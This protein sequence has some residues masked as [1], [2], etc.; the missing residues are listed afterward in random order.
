MSV[1]LCGGQ[2]TL[3]SRPHIKLISGL[4]LLVPGS[5]DRFSSLSFLV[6]LLMFKSV[7]CPLPEVP[8]PV[9][10]PDPEVLC[11]H[12]LAPAFHSLLFVFLIHFRSKPKLHQKG[13]RRTGH[14]CS[15]M[16]STA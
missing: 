16:G 4:Y 13:G 9:C 8:S 12:A 10:L 14:Q 1:N 11:F 5:C 6:F 15:S 2:I 7:S 3:Q